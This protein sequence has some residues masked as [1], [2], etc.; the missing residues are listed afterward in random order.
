MAP[1][2]CLK[3]KVVAVFGASGPTGIGLESAR[4]CAELGGDV[5]LTYLSR[6]EGCIRNSSEL[7][8]SYY[9]KAEAQNFLERVERRS[10]RLVL[11]EHVIAPRSS[12]L[13]SRVEDLDR[14]LSRCTF[15]DTS[16]IFPKSK[17]STCR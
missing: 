13:I 6:G 1:T 3:G 8:E 9:A 15:Q 12:G 14:S 10:L 4:A 17:F 7:A 16:L 2:F 5:A 11:L